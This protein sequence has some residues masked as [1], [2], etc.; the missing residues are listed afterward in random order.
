[1]A[2]FL[3]I[4]LSVVIAGS[5]GA[6]LGFGLSFT[7]KV[8]DV[9]KD[10]KTNQLEKALPGFNCGACGYV[11]C[12]SYAQALREGDIPLTFCTPGGEKVAKTLAKI[13]AVEVS[14]TKE[15]KVTQV[16]CRGG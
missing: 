10:E 13:M 15:K 6:L 4:L 14:F 9:T 7:A 16:H 12:S 2:I 11:R 5:L 8:F 3:N 1:V